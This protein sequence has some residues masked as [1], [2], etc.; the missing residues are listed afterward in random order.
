MKKILVKKILMNK[1]LKKIKY[2]M[3]LIFVF[4]AFRVILGYPENTYLIYRNHMVKLIF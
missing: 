4:E 2:R 3:W 1:I